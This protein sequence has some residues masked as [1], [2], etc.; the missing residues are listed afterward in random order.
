MNEKTFKIV[1]LVTGSL[2]AIVAVLFFVA[3]IIQLTNLQYAEGK[4]I[5]YVILVALLDFAFAAFLC[6]SSLKMILGF[7]KGKDEFMFAKFAI[8]TILLGI[9]LFS[10]LGIIFVS[11]SSAILWVLFIFAGIGFALV[12]ITFVTKLDNM[13]N[14]ILL[15][16][17]GVI[18]FVV[19]IL[20][21]VYTNNGLAIAT[22]IFVMFMVLA[23][24]TYVILALASGKTNQ[25]AKN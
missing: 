16:V 7:T 1:T 25:V 20:E 9:V 10:L 22:Y 3:G 17:S 21:L 2:A 6:L 5:A 12:V 14:A 13:T 18:G 8:A 23:Y 11:V 24:L 15:L 19:T 4:A